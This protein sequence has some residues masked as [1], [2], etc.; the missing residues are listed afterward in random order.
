[1]SR[2]VR[3]SV[4]AQLARPI[5]RLVH[6]YVLVAAE[7]NLTVGAAKVLNVPNF[8]CVSV[9]SEPSGTSEGD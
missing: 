4:V 1:M 9:Y 7:R 2:R 3:A 8:A 6:D 5:Q